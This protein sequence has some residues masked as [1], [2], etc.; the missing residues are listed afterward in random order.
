MLDCQGKYTQTPYQFMD[1]M[2]PAGTRG[3]LASSGPLDVP[4]HIRNCMEPVSACA[5]GPGFFERAEACTQ[6]DHSDSS[7]RRDEE[8]MSRSLW[9]NSRKMAVI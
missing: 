1:V 4:Q 8:R 2:D 3:P 9:G 7:Q 5:Q 6:Y